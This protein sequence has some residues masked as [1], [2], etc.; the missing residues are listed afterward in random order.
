MAN[1]LDSLRGAAAGAAQG[2]LAQYAGDMLPRPAGVAPPQVVVVQGRE[3]PQAPA[4]KSLMDYV[5]SP[6]GIAVGVGLIGLGIWLAL[7]K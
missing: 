3:N 7:R 4:G 1:L 6:V 5:K 2:A